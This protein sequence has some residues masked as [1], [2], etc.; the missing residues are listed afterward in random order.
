[1]QLRTFSN[2]E[3]TSNR[4]RS[5]WIQIFL[6]MNSIRSKMKVRKSWCFISKSWTSTRSK[7]RKNPVRLLLGFE[8]PLEM[9]RTLL[10]RS[11]ALLSKPRKIAWPLRKHQFKWLLSKIRTT[12]SR[13]LE[14]IQNLEWILLTGTSLLHIYS[15]VKPQDQQNRTLTRSKVK[16]N[17]SEHFDSQPVSKE[18]KLSYIIFYLCRCIIQY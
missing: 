5:R 18:E 12:I 13:S 14:Q 4:S 8:R 15:L 2:R 10:L 6:R 17:Y 16:S 1:M 11:F 3:L 9:L 7:T